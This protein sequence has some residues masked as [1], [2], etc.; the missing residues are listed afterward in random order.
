LLNCVIPKRGVLCCFGRDSA[1]AANEW[2]KR[3][4]EEEEEEDTPLHA[5]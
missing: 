5:V 1:R 3:G 4:G 2:T